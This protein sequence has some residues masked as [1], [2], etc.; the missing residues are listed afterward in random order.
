MRVDIIMRTYDVIVSSLTRSR[1]SAVMHDVPVRGLSNRY[2]VF[3]ED[4]DSVLAYGHSVPIPY[5]VSK[6]D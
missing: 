5:S 1:N 2:V 6:R 3:P 4:I